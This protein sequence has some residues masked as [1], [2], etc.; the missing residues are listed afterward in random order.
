[1]FAVAAIGVLIVL[2][3]SALAAAVAIWAFID[4]LVRPAQAFLAAGKA[5]KGVWIALTAAAVAITGLGVASVLPGL[6]G[7][8]Q[9]AA[10]VVSVVY[11]VDVRPA[12]RG[13]RRPP[14][15]PAGW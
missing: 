2:V 3:L 11:L 6:G 8:A 5:K 4:A 12:V 15:Q 7:I 1:M 10:V 9:V 13:S 14:D